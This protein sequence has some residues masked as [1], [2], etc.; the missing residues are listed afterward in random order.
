MSQIREE[1]DPNQSMLNQ[2]VLTQNIMNR[3]DPLNEALLLSSGS[4]L[5]ASPP[6]GGSQ[7][8]EGGDLTQVGET[9][10]GL[11]DSHS[12]L[13]ETALGHTELGETALGHTELGDTSIVSGPDG[14]PEF[15]PNHGFHIQQTSMHHHQGYY[16]EKVFV[17]K[18]TNLDFTFDGV[19]SARR[20]Q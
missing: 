11:G 16:S 19:V 2:S 6:L 5:L 17:P 8:T 1:S 4:E 12:G 14:G 18:S 13:G 15:G 20:F 7:F 3:T 9:E 10:M